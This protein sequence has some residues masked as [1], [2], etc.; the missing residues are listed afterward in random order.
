MILIST[1]KAVRPTN[2]MGASKRLAE[3]IVLDFS[4]KNKLLESQIFHNKTKFSLVR[5]GNVIGS[6]GSVIPLFEKQIKEGG[7]ITITHKDI[8]RFFMTLQEAAQL[9]LHVTGIA[10]G[11]EVFLLDMG[12]PVSIK[13]LAEQMIKLSGL[14]LK[15]DKNPNGDIEI[16]YM[17]LRPGEKLR[18]TFD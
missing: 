7:P 6:S 10:K 8:N 4:E 1:D 5:F 16:I 17:G 2:V 13:Y 3:Q 9:V 15:D 14:T 18:R 12:K 11:G